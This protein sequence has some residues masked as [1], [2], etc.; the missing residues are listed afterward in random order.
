MAHRYGC[1]NAIRCDGYFVK[2]GI[3]MNSYNEGLYIMKW[4]SD[5]MSRDCRYDMNWSDPK[6]SGCRERPERTA[7]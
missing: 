6:C 4:H 7:L 5:T 1:H 2:D 3:T